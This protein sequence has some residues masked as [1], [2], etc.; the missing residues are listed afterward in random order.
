MGYNHSHGH[1]HNHGGEGNIGV[2]FFL[3][4]LLR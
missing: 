2:A 1:G 4:Y 3:M